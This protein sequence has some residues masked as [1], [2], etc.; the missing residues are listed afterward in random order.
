[1][2]QLTVAILVKLG[3]G[4]SQVLYLGLRNPGSNVRQCRLSKLGL[5]DILLHVLQHQRIQLHQVVLQ[6]SLLLDPRVL[7]RFLGRQPHI[8]RPL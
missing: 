3:E 7:K 4:R 1:M 6:V 2:R 5:G 8:G